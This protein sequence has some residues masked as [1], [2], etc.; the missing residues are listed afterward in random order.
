[1]PVILDPAL[2]APWLDPDAAEDELIEMLRPLPADVLETREISDAV[3]DVRNDA[4]E[5]LEPR[6]EELKLL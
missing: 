1:M 2:E 6:A 4:P 5:L 3:N